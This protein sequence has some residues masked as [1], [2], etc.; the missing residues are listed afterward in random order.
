[1]SEFWE[2]RLRDNPEFASNV[3]DSRYTELVEDYSV[4]AIDARKVSVIAFSTMP[5]ILSCI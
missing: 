4:E 5:S 2:W 3:G 1:M